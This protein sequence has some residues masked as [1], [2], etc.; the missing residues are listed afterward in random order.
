[1]KKNHKVSLLALTL[2]ALVGLYSCE[3]RAAEPTSKVQ[4]SASNAEES[5]VV[6][7]EDFERV[8]E[9]SLQIVSEGGHFVTKKVEGGYQFTVYGGNP[10]QEKVVCRGGGVSFVKCVKSYVDQGHHIDVYAYGGDYCGAI[11]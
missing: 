11:P 6:S 1:M 9:Q 4:A 10:T 5:P 7:E 3:K 8:F 2:A